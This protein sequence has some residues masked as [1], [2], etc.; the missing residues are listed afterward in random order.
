MSHIFIWMLGFNA[1]NSWISFPPRLKRCMLKIHPCTLSQRY[2]MMWHM[3]FINRTFV[4]PRAIQVLLVL[5]S[6]ASFLKNLHLFPSYLQDT[7]WVGG[8]ISPSPHAEHISG[9]STP[10]SALRKT[11]LQVLLSRACTAVPLCDADPH[12][13]RHLPHLV[14]SKYNVKSLC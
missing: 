11:R 4:S 1:N 10:H 12:H 7:Q 6:N 14:Y 5:W 9:T 3:W 8:Y 13:W 2:Q